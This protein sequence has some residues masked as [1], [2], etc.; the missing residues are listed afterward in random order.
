M[1]KKSTLKEALGEMYLKRSSGNTTRL[2][3][4]AVQIIFSGYICVVRDHYNRG[5]DLMANTILFEK[6]QMRLHLEHQ[7]Q[8]DLFNFD[9]EN[10][11]IS[12]YPF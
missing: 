2:I 8:V 11:E 1:D 9:K 3:D 12:L 6:I 4:T 10:L 7:N 5:N